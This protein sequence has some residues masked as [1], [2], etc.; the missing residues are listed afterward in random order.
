MWVGVI[1]R[2]ACV[3]GLVGSSASAERRAWV[4]PGTLRRWVRVEMEEALATQPQRKCTDM[5]WGVR[6]RHAVAA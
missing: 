6:G 5:S 2:S 1:V 4:Q 3:S